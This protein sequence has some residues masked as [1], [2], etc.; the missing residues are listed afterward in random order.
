MHTQYLDYTDGNVTCQ[1]FIA[2]E[3]AR[4]AKRPCVL[5]SHSWAGQ[6]DAERAKAEEFARMGYVGIAIDVYGKGIRGSH[7]ADNSALMAPY[8]TDRAMLRK[9]M[10]AA[11][12]A[13]RAYPM[14][15]PQRIAAIG[16]CFGGLCVLDLARSGISDVK[17]VVSIHGLFAPPRLGDQAPISA[18][19]LLL[20]GWD[21]PMAKPADVLAITQELTAAKADWQLHAYGHTMHAFTHAQAAAPERGL[22][23]NAAAARRSWTATRNFL[24]EV[25]A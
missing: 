1:A 12:E 7:S 10:L 6:S 8:M 20:H 5:I 23:Y 16:Y 3:D 14:V 21:D 24:E 19:V 2:H 17:G 25:F 18:K 15:D 9:R 4:G 22:L 11:V 13:A